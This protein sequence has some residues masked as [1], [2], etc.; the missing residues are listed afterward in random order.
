MD[1]G[2]HTCNAADVWGH[3]G[4]A[5]IVMN[6][7]GKALALKVCASVAP[8]LSTIFLLLLLLSVHAASQALYLYDCS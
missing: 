6:V 5:T 4:T 7:T 2:T 3:S 8:T 1:S